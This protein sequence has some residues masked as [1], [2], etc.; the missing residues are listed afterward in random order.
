MRSDYGAKYEIPDETGNAKDSVREGEGGERDLFTSTGISG[1]E[2][3]TQSA[4]TFSVH[5]EAIE[6][7]TLPCLLDSAPLS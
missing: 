1:E 2:A 3:R 7:G 5:Y 4:D 6:V